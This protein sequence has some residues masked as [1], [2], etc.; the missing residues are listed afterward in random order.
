MKEAVDALSNKARASR[1]EPFGLLTRT[2]QVI[3]NASVP[4]PMAVWEL[5][6]LLSPS[7]DVGD[8]AGV[9]EVSLCS[10]V[11]CGR[12]HFLH[13]WLDLQSLLK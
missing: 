3:I 9:L 6:G 12:W 7:G 13:L 11:W 5:T 8:A 1:V 2:M 4:I 10:R